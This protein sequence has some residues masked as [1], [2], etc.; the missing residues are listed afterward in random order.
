MKNETQSQPLTGKV[1]IVTGV[2]REHGIGT[3]TCERLAEAGADIFFTHYCPYDEKDGEGIEEHWPDTLAKKL[4]E[5]GVRVAHMEADLRDKDLPQKL[6]ENVVKEIGVP[7]ILIHNAT[8]S[9]N[10]NY[11]NLTSELLDDHYEVNN[12]GPILL[13]QAF[14]K[15][16]EKK[17]HSEEGGSI[18]F[19]VSGGPDP[20]NLA[21]I[22][23]KGAL[24]A[25]TPPL[26]TGLAPIGINVNAVDP[27]PTDTG[28]MDPGTKEGL[29]PLFPKG[30]LGTAD[31]AAKLIRFLVSP[32]ASWV[33]GQVIHSDGGFLGR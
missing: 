31:D 11:K 32:D 18:I 5:R 7:S 14:A 17:F 16:Y 28:W 2:S 10:S 15:L 23:T 8:F 30:R 6:L 33:T 24:K 25:F 13:T 26:A 9:V 3:S 27:G 1:A 4:D 20:D 22:A 12:K 19:L 21:Y 29:L